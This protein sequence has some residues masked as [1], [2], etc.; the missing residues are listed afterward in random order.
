MIHRRSLFP[1]L[2]TYFL[3]TFGLAIVYPVFTPLLLALDGNFVPIATPLFE[4]SVVLGLLIA[5]FPIA[6]F[7]GAPFL[8]E[9]SD[10][11][12]RK[13]VLS[14]SILGT[15]IG[16][17][18]SA[19][20]IFATDLPL[21]FLGRLWTGLFAGNLT[22]CL[23]SVADMSLL[24]AERAKNFGLLGAC[25][26]LS[27]V[28]AILVSGGLSALH[29]SLPFW[30][31]GALSL[32]NLL[33]LFLFFQETHKTKAIEKI[34]LFRGIHDLKKALATPGL[35]HVY[36]VYF[37]FMAAWSS[38]M[39]FL[40]TMLFQEYHLT[41]QGIT[42]MFVGIGMIWSVMN[43]GVNRILAHYS[44]PPQTLRIALFFLGITLLLTLFTG[45]VGLFIP[46]F[47]AAS[48]C[49]SLA[50]TNGI[51]TVSLTAPGSV[52]GCVLGMNQSIGAVAVILGP[53]ISGFL[54]GVNPHL[55]F[56]VAGLAALLGSIRPLAKL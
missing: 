17:A 13:K 46:V 35:R 15:S 39:Q 29:P 53:A 42:M 47:L 8:G 45:R 37:F 18:I 14:F 31:T 25:G 55:V 34:Q 6:Q 19:I 48:C 52:Q 23:A 44:T 30:V 11:I 49:G 2:L 41:S 10:R 4:R 22:I 28:I 9:L 16:Y 51:A 5:A 38:A 43:L 3:D 26:G 12:G 24:K 50:W 40:P 1:I 7:F 33:C 32:V 27:F 20:G 21:L 54:A 56:F 36:L